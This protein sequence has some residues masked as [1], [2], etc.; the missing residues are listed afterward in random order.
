MR[1]VPADAFEARYRLD[2]DPWRFATS[3]YEQRRFDITVACLPRRRFRRAFEPACAGGDLTIRLS[4]RC[5]E[6]VACDASPTVVRRARRRVGDAADHECQIEIQVGEVP[7]WWPSGRFDLI[8]MSEIGYYF[9]P[10][11]LRQLVDRLGASLTD[12]GALVAV[13]WLGTSG[14]HL[15][16]GDE[17]HDI[18]T[19]GM[20]GRPQGGFRDAGFRLDWWG[21]DGP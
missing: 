5:D 3:E 21:A 6:L 4:W 9:D 17:V 7:S 18:V 11:A 10:P 13:H 20:A 19:A 14:D 15:L 1:Q 16:S 8:V 2:D 12:D